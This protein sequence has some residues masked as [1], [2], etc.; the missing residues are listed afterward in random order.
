[1]VFKM[2]VGGVVSAPGT[3]GQAEKREDRIAEQHRC[4]VA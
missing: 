4:D 1:M 3:G 2:L